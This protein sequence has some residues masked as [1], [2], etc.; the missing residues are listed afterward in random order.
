MHAFGH[1]KTEVVCQALRKALTPVCAGVGMSERGLDPDL[2]IAHRD[3]ADRHVVRPQVK[4]AAAFKIEASVVP[5]TGQDTVFDTAAIERK[6]HMRAPI[7][8]RE[9]APAVVN[10]QDWAMAT[11]HNEPPLRLQLR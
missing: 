3:R 4:G 11:M 1:D 6:A 7:V 9:D 5:M 8:E 10:D 2:A